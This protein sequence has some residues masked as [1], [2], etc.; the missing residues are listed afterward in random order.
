MARLNYIIPATPVY[1]PI[2]L[3]LDD[4][5]ALQVDMRNTWNVAERRRMNPI[6]SSE[7]RGSG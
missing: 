7:E 5:G 3:T 6:D 2:D 4:D 1:N